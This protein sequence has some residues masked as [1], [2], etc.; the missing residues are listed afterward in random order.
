MN[1]LWTW[2]QEERPRRQN[3]RVHDAHTVR[4]N[5]GMHYESTATAPIGVGLSEGRGC[6]GSP[7]VAVWTCTED[8][9]GHPKTM[10]VIVETRVSKGCKLTN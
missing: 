5:R 2:S 7:C 1:G 6:T 10:L 3:A 9:A 8:R 4:L